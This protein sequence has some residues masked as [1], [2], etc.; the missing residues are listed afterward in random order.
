MIYGYC[1]ISTKKQSL[2]R[3]ELN[4]LSRYKNAKIIKEVFTG[5]KIERKEFNKLLS[6]INKGD[7]IVFDEISRMSRDSKDGYKLY[8][9]LLEKGVNL[10]FLKEQH[11]NTDTFKDKLKSLDIDL[12]EENNNSDILANDIKK[13]FYKFQVN[14]LK[15]DIEQAFKSAEHEVNFLSMRTKEGLKAVKEKNKLIEQGIIKGDIKQIGT[16]KGDTFNIKKKQP[17][18]DKIIELSK[19]FNGTL[20]DCDIIKIL[21]IARNTYYKYKQ[22]IK[23]SIIDTNNKKEL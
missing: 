15:Y 13:A 3:Q 21:G 5:R 18:K 16:K 11:C 20:K 23:T 17:C 9:E 8:M 4:I 10:V 12:I 1:R 2:K 19:D 14:N 7:T 6:I 22:E